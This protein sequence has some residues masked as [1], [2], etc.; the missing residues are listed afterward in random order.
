MDLTLQFNSFR[1]GH[2]PKGNE[3]TISE[4]QVQVHIVE[5]LAVA[6]ISANFNAYQPKM[7]KGNMRCVRSHTK[8]ANL[9][10]VTAGMTLE[11]AML[12]EGLAQKGKYNMIPALIPRK[13]RAGV[14]KMVGKQ[15]LHNVIS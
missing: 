3:I 14:K 12:R 13:Q 5:A 8:R 7:G 4:R 6:R 1:T 15:E 11:E 10:F 2:K 9:S